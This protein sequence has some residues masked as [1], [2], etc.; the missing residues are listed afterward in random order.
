MHLFEPCN[1]PRFFTLPPGA[2]FTSDLVAG[3]DQ[4]LAG[5]PPHLLA[6]ITIWVNTQRARRSLMDQFAAGGP[7]LLPRI[8]V[9]T[10]L[11]SDPLAPLKLPEP[12]SAL[13]RKLELARLV[14]G[15]IDTEPG[16]AAQTAA[17]DLA[18]SLSDLL[19][20]LQGEGLDPDVFAQVEP[21]EHAA[22][23]QRN[24][25]F[26]NILG[27][28]V[29]GSGMS[30]GQGRLRAQALAW[31]ETWKTAPPQDPVL[32]VGS[33]GSRSA[34]RI[35]MEAVARLPQGAVVLPGFDATQPTSVWKRLQS[36][37]TAVSDHPQ[38]G[39]QRLAEVIGFD[40]VL[41]PRWVD[42]QPPSP[43]RNALVSLA[44]RPAPV[45]DQWQTEG[46]ALVDDL[47]QAMEDVTWLEAANSRSEAR[48]IAFVLRQALETDGTAALITPDR[49]LARRVTSELDRWGIIPDDSAGRPLVLTPPGVLLLLLADP[50]LQPLT[51]ESL[52]VLLK[53]PLVNSVASARRQHMDFVSR[54]ET[55]ELRGGAPFVDWPRMHAWAVKL[56]EE[57]VTWVTWLETVLSSPAPDVAPLAEHAAWHKSFAENLAEGPE[58]GSTHGL[59]DRDA[60][61]AA[62]AVVEE[63]AA[64]TDIYG[65]MD[66]HSYL[67]LLR[68]QLGSK[69][70]PEEAVVTNSRLAIWGTLEARVQSADTIILGG[71]NEG[72]WPRQPGADPWLSRSLRRDIGL[73][74]PDQKIG[75]S[76]HDF[77]QAMGAPRVVVSRASREDGSPTVASRWLLRLENLLNGLGPVGEASLESARARGNSVLALS[78]LLDEPEGDVPSA[79][80]PA[81][82][83]P[84]AAR[85]DRLSVTQIDTLI[86]DPY[87]VYARRVLNL[88]PLDPPGRAAD[89]L[90]RGTVLHS[91]LEE[92]LERTRDDFPDN[93]DEVFLHVTDDVLDREVPWPAIRALW[94]ERLT[95]ASDWFV[96]EERGRR[97]RGRPFHREI[98]ARYDVPDLAQPLKLSAQA[99]RI[100]LLP[101][102]TFAIYDY[103]SGSIPSEKQAKHF[104]TQLPLEAVLAER[105]AFDK[106][107]AARVTHLELIGINQRK[108]LILPSDHDALTAVWE[109]F[110]SLMRVYQDP[111]TPFV[112]RLRPHRIAFEGAYDHLSRRG[113]WSDGDPF[114]ADT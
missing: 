33:T 12:T 98:S 57:A 96:Q 103:K 80:R 100:D 34:T 76:A 113:E 8:R 65:P 41:L 106:I 50:A 81:P 69:D 30:T 47:P 63:L 104:H 74:L 7:R 48:A 44:M 70:V 101:D 58:A 77:Q 109:G 1:G 13:E 24:L 29:A 4:R 82:R 108:S 114:G 84:A 73:P 107:A 5:Q 105:G 40:P 43:E 36:D 15:L 92:F 54:I 22:H 66:R 64:S 28:Y 3:L 78:T 46:K 42:T 87:A 86:R 10:E 75:L 9:I 25:K 2:D 52:L 39:F 31:A 83:P 23:W 88:R 110:M 35:F 95:R 112:A 90:V 37:D 49:T 32:V 111:R 21:A 62:L 61:R 6:K 85:P 91:V 72:T 94:R 59:W 14:S 68:S 67:A 16:L 71:L 79:S 11:A 20:E 45:T 18:D 60:G 99:D 38:N 53:H 56:G 55:A 17:F 89:A 26:L 102:C 93:A 27:H 97:E 19:D 51:P